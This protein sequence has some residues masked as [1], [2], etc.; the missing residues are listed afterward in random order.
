MTVPSSSGQGGGADRRDASRRRG[1]GGAAVVLRARESLAHGEGRQRVRSGRSCNARRRAG[2][3][4]RSARW[5]GAGGQGTGDAGQTAPLGGGRSSRRFG[6]L[7]NLVYDPM[8]LAEAWMRVRSNTGARTPGVDK[9]TVADIE[10][11]IGAGVFLAGIRD[12]AE[13]RRVPAR[14]SPAGDDPEEKRE[15]PQARD[16]YCRRPGGPGVPEAGA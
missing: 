16:T 4:R 1:R 11:R 7:F 8:F 13:V 14:A 2:E 9:A 3:S 10:N 5:P 12:F 6:D 15:T